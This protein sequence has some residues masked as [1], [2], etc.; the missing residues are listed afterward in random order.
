MILEKAPDVAYQD[1]LNEFI[2]TWGVKGLIV[3][4]SNLVV[5]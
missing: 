1:V 2:S 5:K 3:T 4:R